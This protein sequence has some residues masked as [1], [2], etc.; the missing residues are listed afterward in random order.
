MNP[1]EIKEFAAWIE[2]NGVVFFGE[3]VVVVRDQADE[4]L[5][6][7]IIIASKTHQKKQKRGTV[8]AIG[9]GI[10]EEHKELAGLNIGDRVIF[11]VYNTLELEIP[12]KNG[13]PH[14]VQVFHAADIYAGFRKLD[15]KIS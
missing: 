10:D 3:K 8:V 15:L 6:S 14:T 9:L 13:V 11:N 2:A 7:G 5:G 12:D 4:T 1:Q